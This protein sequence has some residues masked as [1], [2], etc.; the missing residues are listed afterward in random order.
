MERIAYGSDGG[1]GGVLSLDATGSL[2]T[3][4]MFCWEVNEVEHSGDEV[5][6]SI[7]EGDIELARHG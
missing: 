4:A 3:A 6:G 2:S 1:S 5:V 7:E